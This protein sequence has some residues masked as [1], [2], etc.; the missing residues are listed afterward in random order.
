MSSSAIAP[1][2]SSTLG[3]GSNNNKSSASK[4]D[5]DELRK[6]LRSRLQRV[7]RREPLDP[8]YRYLLRLG[9]SR[10][11][12]IPTKDKLYKKMGSDLRERVE[13]YFQ[14]GGDDAVGRKRGRHRDALEE[15]AMKA[16]F[17]LRNSKKHEQDSLLSASLASAL[18]RRIPGS[19]VDEGTRRK[20]IEAMVMGLQEKEKKK[21]QKID[22][23]VLAAAK[24]KILMAEKTILLKE[25]EKA[26][27]FNSKEKAA[28]LE[29]KLRQKEKE[30][31]E[32]KDQDIE[33]RERQRNID[34]ARER[35]RER[36][37]A[38]K[39]TVDEERSR[40]QTEKED[41]LRRARLAE[42]PQQALHRLYEPIFRALWDMEFANLHGTNPFRLVIDKKNC[43]DM[44]VP[45]YCDIIKK[46]MNLTYIQEKVEAK[47]YESLQ[48]FFADVEL[49]VSNALLYNSDPGNEFHVAAKDLKRKSKKLAKRVV[50][51]LQTQQNS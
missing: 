13:A 37:T 7:T 17:S 9:S 39:K 34:K 32:A 36:E 43:A 45:D 23:K 15:D 21:R 6:M 25:K 42:T 5:G 16:G 29:E 49:L 22:N 12:Q 28:A 8:S 19:M 51:M 10:P 18:G 41:E 35:E 47:T 38:R 33:D 14:N 40:V 24:Q 46:P 30:R 27:T 2:R 50:Q 44:G 31:H 20:R 1:T 48:E 26:L 4:P 11:P 3:D